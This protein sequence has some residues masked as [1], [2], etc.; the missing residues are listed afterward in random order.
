MFLLWGNVALGVLLSAF[1]ITAAASCFAWLVV[2]R[3][4]RAQAGA[5]PGDLRA[6]RVFWVQLTT[7]SLSKLVDKQ[8]A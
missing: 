5:S 3:G 4:Q 1:E 7:R 2:I 8:G 6:Y